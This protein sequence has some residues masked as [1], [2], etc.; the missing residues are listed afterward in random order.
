METELNQVLEHMCLF[1]RGLGSENGQIKDENLWSRKGP[2]TSYA[3]LL[4]ARSDNNGAKAYV[5]R[6]LER[7]IAGVSRLYVLAREEQKN[8][9][10]QVVTEIARTGEYTVEDSF[11]LHRDYRCNN[12]G[13]GA[14]L[15]T[16][17]E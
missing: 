11:D 5:D 4:V 16:K 3:F 9:A 2:V 15:V 10:K 13:Y 14:I 12:G 8:F 17:T 6:A 1:V 7:K